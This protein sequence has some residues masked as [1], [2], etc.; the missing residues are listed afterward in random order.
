MYGEPQ[1]PDVATGSYNVCVYL[2]LI[3]ICLHMANAHCWLTL[4]LQMEVFHDGTD[5]KLRDSFGQGRGTTF[6]A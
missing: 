1:P 3:G 4:A 6:D 5:A 2:L